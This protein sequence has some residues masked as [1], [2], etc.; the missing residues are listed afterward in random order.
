MACCGCCTVI[1]EGAMNL[2]DS[3]GADRLMP[4][5]MTSQPE[6]IIRWILNAQCT[7]CE[8]VGLPEVTL[9]AWGAPATLAEAEEQSVYFGATQ[10]RAARPPTR[11]GL[12]PV[13]QQAPYA[14]MPDLPEL[15]HAGMYVPPPSPFAYEG[16]ARPP[17]APP[18]PPTPRG[19]FDP[20]LAEAHDDAIAGARAAR[21]RNQGSLVFG[22]GNW[23]SA[24]T[25][26]PPSAR[27]RGAPVGGYQHYSEPEQRPGSAVS[28]QASEDASSQRQRFKARGNAGSFVFG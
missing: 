26:A 18:A 11:E 23:D 25:S 5:T 28:M 10:P 9:A 27:G 13:P 4:L 17:A 3:I 1:T 24:P 7:L 19:D 14:T 16:R 2:R 6:K 15:V 21:L 8:A 22:G 12:P 20:R